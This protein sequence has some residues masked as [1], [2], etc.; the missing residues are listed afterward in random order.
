MEE[1]YRLGGA[2][3][4]REAKYIGVDEVFYEVEGAPMDARTTADDFTSLFTEIY[5]YFHS[6]RPSG[7]YRPTPESLAVLQHLAATG[8]LTM[9]E[10]AAHFDRSGAA[11]SEMVDRLI[12]RGLLERMPDERDRRRHLV[13]LTA[14]GQRVMKAESRPLDTDRLSA[15]LEGF[16]EEQRGALI[17][18]MNQLAVAARAGAERRNN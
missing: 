4:G 15:V 13:W 12:K 3:A 9:S 6:R 11:M 17:A 5:L 14:E 8:P 10:A 2:G 16:T 1:V 7:E 18:A